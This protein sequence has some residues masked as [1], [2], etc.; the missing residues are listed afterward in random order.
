MSTFTLLLAY[1]I[2]VAIIF[3]FVYLWHRTSPAKGSGWALFGAVFVSLCMSQPNNAFVGVVAFGIMTAGYA[4]IWVNAREKKQSGWL[5]A[6]SILSALATMD[7]I[8]K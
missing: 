4:A 7:S 3:G 1:L 8:M 6:M 2:G 5:L